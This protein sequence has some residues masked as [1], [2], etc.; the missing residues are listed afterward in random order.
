MCHRGGLRDER[1]GDDTWRWPWA[2]EDVRAG[3]GL[4]CGR[5]PVLCG[6]EAAVDDDVLLPPRRGMLWGEDDGPAAA[7]PAALEA[8][9]APAGPLEEEEDVD[10]STPPPP[11]P[12]LM[13][14]APGSLAMPPPLEAAGSFPP[15]G[16]GSLTGC[17]RALSAAATLVLLGALRRLAFSA[18]AAF[19]RSSFSKCAKSLAEN[20]SMKPSSWKNLVEEARIQVAGMSAQ[21]STA[22]RRAAVPAQN[23]VQQTGGP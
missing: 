20:F 17:V 2:G 16:G 22:A 21:C 14:M 6:C 4:S 12:P 10:G 5:K 7:G 3:A 9:P 1:R 18:N 8:A 19:C 11:P 23:K 15:K 13:R